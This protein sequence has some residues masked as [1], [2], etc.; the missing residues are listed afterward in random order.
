MYIFYKQYKQIRGGGLYNKNCQKHGKWTLL[1]DNFFM[2]N[3]I[4]YI[5]SFQDGEKVGQWD[6]MK[7]QIQ[8][9]NLIFEKI[10]QKIY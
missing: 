1:S 7:I 2:Y 10:G 5:G 9:D 3:L 8:D 6:I 4:T